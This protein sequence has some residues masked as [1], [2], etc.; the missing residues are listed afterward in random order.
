[1]SDRDETQLD[2]RMRLAAVEHLK[3]V[4]AGGVLTSDD[5]KVGCLPIRLEG[6]SL[7]EPARSCNMC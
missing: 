2:T 1:M 6:V 7:A 4:S 5:L 3:R